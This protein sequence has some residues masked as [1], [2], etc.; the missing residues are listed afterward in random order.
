MKKLLVFLFTFLISIATVLFSCNYCVSYC[1]ALNGSNN[2]QDIIE[3]F[4]DK[5][6]KVFNINSS[7]KNTLRLM[8]NNQFYNLD[9]SSKNSIT[10]M[11]QNVNKL[12][13]NQ[14]NYIINKI[15]NMGFGLDVALNYVYN[16]LNKQVESICNKIEKTPIDAMPISV[17][18]CN[19]SFKDCVNGISV[20]KFAL[21]YDIYNALIS[22]ETVNIKTFT[23]YANKTLLDIKD[24]YKLAGK[25]YT[26][27]D[28]SGQA[29]R[30][31]IKR[32][33]NAING[34][35]IKNGETFSFNTATGAR[36]AENGYKEAKI[37]VGGTY[38][39][40]FG[41]GVCQVSTTLY[42]AC[43]L[44]GLD[45][46]EVHNHSLPSSYVNPCFDAMVNTGSSD[47]KVTNNT[48]YDCII[49][50][51]AENGKCNVVIYGK[52][53]AY[54]IVRRFEKYQELPA[55]ADI[56]ETDAS[57]YNTTYLPGS[58][59]ISYPID[60]FRAKGYLDYYDGDCL[61]KSKKIRDN[62]YNPKKGIT[63]IVK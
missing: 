8:Y 56:I 40:G 58:Y 33:C 6:V 7:N 42:N 53:P 36:T 41:G 61:I 10:K 20:D 31:N 12:N 44:A 63:L 47:L 48:G 11:Q 32:A 23:T 25:F 62:T 9:L 22:Q 46:A 51:S 54:K 28:S 14:K 13:N 5:D 2:Y 4:L 39:D 18:N 34:K 24:N 19:I 43:L 26:S 52:E 50:A 45:I 29:R 21:Y 57:K 55:G 35:I 27:F 37:I 49:T 30:S 16:G 3:D 1:M 38:I 60:G 15:L 17:G 59:Q